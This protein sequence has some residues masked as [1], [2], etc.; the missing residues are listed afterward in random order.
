[1]LALTLLLAC[2]DDPCAGQPG[3]RLHVAPPAPEDTE[4]DPRQFTSISAALI[5][6]G[7]GASVCVAPGT[8]RE[9]VRLETEGVKLLGAGAE[10]TIIEP[11]FTAADPADGE[12]TVIA[13][14]ADD[15]EVRGFTVRGGARGVWVDAGLDATLGELTITDNATG[16]L[17]IDPGQLR[18]E[19]VELLHNVSVGGLIVSTQD[20]PALS[21]S[22]GRIAGNGTSDQS[23]VG[24]LFS[25]RPVHLTDVELRDNAGSLAADLYTTSRLVMDGGLVGR[26]YATAPAPRLYAGDGAVLTD[27]QARTDGGPLLRVTCGASSTFDAENLAVADKTGA[28]P[29]LRVSGCAGTLAHLT[30]VNQSG[31]AD[32]TAVALDGG[33]QIDVRSSALLAYTEP[34]QESGGPERLTLTE[35]FVGGLSAARLMAPLDIEPDLRP[36]PDSP[37]IDAAPSSL[38]TADIDGRPRPLGEAP[39]QGAFE[40]P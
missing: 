6:A 27:V 25:E 12:H 32:T 23:E 7:P 16:L 19:S 11:R 13:I 2:A 37:L 33:A 3:A 1:M 31:E 29:V 28:G 18:L 10:R 38:T 24:G 8:Y 26:P 15:A 22:G 35:S 40:L 34:E 9:P 39:D 21:I 4:S 30:L 5:A 20:G 36:Q 17:A 14:L